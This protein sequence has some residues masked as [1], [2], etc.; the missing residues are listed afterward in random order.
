MPVIG[1]TA[2][3]LFSARE[4]NSAHSS[5]PSHLAATNDSVHEILGHHHMR[6]GIDDGHVSSG[7][8]LEVVIGLDVRRADQVDTTR[9][10][11]D[12]LRALA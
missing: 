3:G 8:Q 4:M 5:N 7:P 10:D 11:D 9:V 12:E 1:S 2:S 6:H